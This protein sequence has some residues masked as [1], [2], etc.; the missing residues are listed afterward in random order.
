MAEHTHAITAIAKKAKRFKGTATCTFSQLGELCV[1]S[2][3]SPEKCLK[4][5]AVRK[6]INDAR[7]DY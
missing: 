1:R 4:P 7:F 3:F 5:L 6:K 2:R